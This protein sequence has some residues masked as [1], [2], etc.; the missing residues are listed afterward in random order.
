MNQYCHF[1]L[2]VEGIIWGEVRLGTGGRVGGPGW[3][4]GVGM[5][6]E[7]GANCGCG[8]GGA[9]P[10]LECLAT[11]GVS[12]GSFLLLGFL[13]TQGLAICST[14]GMLWW[15]ILSIE[16]NNSMLRFDHSH[17]FQQALCFLIQS[18]ISYFRSSALWF[19][20]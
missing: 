1:L 8:C 6:G 14:I 17:G 7:R 12:L 13:W 10:G 16:W 2:F 9:R 20:L 18:I 5:Q 4:R 3:S 19:F 15:F 11:W